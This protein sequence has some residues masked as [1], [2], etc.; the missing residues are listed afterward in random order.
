MNGQENIIN[1]ILSDA[2]SRCACIVADAEKVALST[3]QTA[4]Q[5][6]RDDSAALDKRIAAM[7]EE[8]VRNARAN[9]EL[10][11][12]KYRLQIRQQLISSCYDEAYQRLAALNEED[13]LDFVGGLLSRYAEEGE[14]V[15]ITKADSKLVTQ[16]WLNGFEKRLKLG[17]R[18]IHADGGV[19]LEGNGY[20]KDLTLKRVVQYLREQTESEVALKLGVR[21]E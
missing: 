8:R 5:S 13:R 11:A 14:T 4:E 16:G 12:K 18:F 1:K 7:K 19:V 15:Y 2:D 21:N 6:V 10:D 3:V 9:A 20:E 17:N